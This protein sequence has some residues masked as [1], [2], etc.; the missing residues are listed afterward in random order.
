[1]IDIILASCIYTIRNQD[2]EERDLIHEK[3]IQL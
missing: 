1:M 2:S 3:Y